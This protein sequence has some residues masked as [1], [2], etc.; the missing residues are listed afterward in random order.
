MSF[1][2]CISIAT[3]HAFEHG[4]DLPANLWSNTIVSEAAML[5]G[6][7]SDLVGCTNWD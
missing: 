3:H 1:T 5:A 2:D 6:L 4:C 7:D